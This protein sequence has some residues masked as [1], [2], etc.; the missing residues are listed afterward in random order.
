MTDT[1]PEQMDDELLVPAGYMH[2]M[3]WA[4]VAKRALQ[5]EMKPGKRLKLLELLNGLTDNW[6]TPEMLPMIAPA[7]DTEMA[8][9]GEAKSLDGDKD[10]KNSFDVLTSQKVFG[11]FRRL[12]LSFMAAIKLRQQMTA[13]GAAPAQLLGLS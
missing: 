8:M 2:L 10:C 13:T 1:L 12:N 5:W 9:L 11:H 7:G 3:L 6:L 4:A